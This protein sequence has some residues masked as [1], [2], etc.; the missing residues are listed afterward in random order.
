MKNQG[1]VCILLKSYGILF[2]YLT[3]LKKQSIEVFL[4]HL[5]FLKALREVCKRTKIT[6]TTCYTFSMLAVAKMHLYF[7]KNK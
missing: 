3:F 4:G 6:L 1:I 2:P 7:I 5:L